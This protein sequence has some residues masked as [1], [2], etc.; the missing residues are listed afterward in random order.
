[1][2]KRIAVVGGG[3]SGLTAAIAA[4]RKGAAVTVYE[5]QARVGRKILATG[6]GRCNFTNINAAEKNYHGE[7]PDFVRGAIA[8]FWVRETLDFFRELGVL[9]RVEAE[10]KVY[11]YSG[12][13]AAILDVLRME[14]QRLDVQFVCGFET[15]AMRHV[16]GKYRLESYQKEQ[17]EADTV[18]LA[19]GGRAAPDLGSNGSG[20][21]LLEQVGHR[22]VP[23]I[24]ALVQVK[25]AAEYG[26]GLKGMKFDAGVRLMYQ[27]KELGQAAG[28][29]LF[30]EYGLSGPPVFQLSRL[31]SVHK[32]CQIRLDLMP[33]YTKEQVIRLLTA[34]QSPAK[35]LEDYLVGI[36]PKRMGQVLLKSCGIAPLSRIS[37][38]LGG[39]EIERIAAAVKGWTFET[40]G[41]LSWNNAQVTAGGADVREVDPVTFASRKVKNVYIVGELLDIDGDCGGYN[42]QWAWSSGMIAG[43]AAAEG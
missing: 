20:Y 10:G 35:N 23:T 2:K 13:A 19:C 31:V 7:K 36:L 30:T 14:A 38:S 41:T 40:E 11:P 33:E 22:I 39:A 21:R 9:A 16:G 28:E 15:A 43:M 3:A 26:K 29:V 17:A 25:T 4:A 42:L 18:I 24:P 5:R 1:M 12:Q 34:Q 6:N 32:H 37:A 8:R 27:G